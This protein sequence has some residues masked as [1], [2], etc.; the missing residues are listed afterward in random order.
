MRS[1]CFCAHP[2]VAHLLQLSRA[3]SKAWVEQARH[4][5]KRGAPGMVR[6]SFGCYNDRHDV[7]VVV[8]GL[9]QVVAGEFVADYTADVDGSFHPVGYVEPLLFSLDAH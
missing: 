6:I 7:D 9:E 1:G 2:Y 8:R 4:G 3:D 5:D